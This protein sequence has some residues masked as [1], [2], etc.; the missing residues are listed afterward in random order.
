VEKSGLT[1]R[2]AFVMVLIFYLVTIG[3]GYVHFNNLVTNEQTE[4]SVGKRLVHLVLIKFKKD[5][6]PDDLQKITDGA[7]SLQQIEGVFDLNF[8]ENISPEGL[9]KGFSHSLTMKFPS[10]K[11]RDSIYLPHPVHQK[12]VKLFVPF[13]TDVLVYDYWE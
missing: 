7:Y 9:G 12:F 13:T 3:I 1:Y 8:R 2:F 6:L 10:A 11:D 4:I 5:I